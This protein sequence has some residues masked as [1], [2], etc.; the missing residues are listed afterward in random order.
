MKVQHLLTAV[1]AALVLSG[2]GS[3]PPLNFSVPNVGLVQRKID[4]ELKS[5]TV[6]VARQEEKTG[7]LDFK[8]AAIGDVN[9]NEALAAQNIPQQWQGALLESINSMAI[10][11]DDSAKK[12]NL[13]VKILKLEITALFVPTKATTTEARYEITDRKTGDLVFTQNVSSTAKVGI[14]NSM[15][16]LLNVRESI[17]RAIRNNISQFLQALETVDAS[18][19]MFPVKAAS[20]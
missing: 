13:S 7:D 19:P 10:F 5:V 8:F 6:A 3:A 12:F 11:Q 2:C 14:D 15:D 9:P 18:K 16:A 17:N 1:I 20:K 4:A